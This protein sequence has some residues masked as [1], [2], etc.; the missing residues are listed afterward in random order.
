[1]KNPCEIPSLDRILKEHFIENFFKE[2]QISSPVFKFRSGVLSLFLYIY[3]I[4]FTYLRT[5]SCTQYTLYKYNLVCIYCTSRK[6]DAWRIL[7]RSMKKANSLKFGGRLENFLR[8]PLFSNVHWLLKWIWWGNFPCV[9]QILYFF[10]L[11]KQVI[12]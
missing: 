7:R 12:H 1:M 8:E 11:P 5:C 3:D 2:N 4:F 6:R 10:W 9:L